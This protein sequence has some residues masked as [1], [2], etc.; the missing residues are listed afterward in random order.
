MRSHPEHDDET[1]PTGGRR[2][3]LF[4]AVAIVL[5]VLL[6]IVLHLT[7]VIGANSH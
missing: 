2:G 5:V 3:P 7:G 1:E 4:A 6:V